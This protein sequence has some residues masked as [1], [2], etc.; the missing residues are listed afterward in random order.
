MIADALTVSRMLLS[1][2]L[3][4]FS[5]SAALFQPLYLLCGVTDVLDGFLARK[6]HTESERGARLDSAADLLFAVMYAVRILP[7][8]R[9]PGWGWV[10]IAGIAAVK[11]AGVVLAG[12]Q[13]RG[14]LLEH[15]AANRLTGL[16][17]FLLPMTVRFAAVEYGIV[18][19][20]GLATFAAMGDIIRRKNCSL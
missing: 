3:L 4:A 11:I 5:T 2:F 6:L 14:Q 19:V 20:C 1:L 10:W 7:R 16:A 18:A 8:L 13:R 17:V 9:I 15:S 12:I